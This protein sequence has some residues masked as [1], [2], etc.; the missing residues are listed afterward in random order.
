MFIYFEKIYFILKK[1]IFNIKIFPTIQI[2]YILAL[3][4]IKKN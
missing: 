2:K 4:E 1:I 3:Q